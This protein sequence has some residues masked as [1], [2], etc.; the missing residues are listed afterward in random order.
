MK[1]VSQATYLSTEYKFKVHTIQQLVC[2][3]LQVN[4][5]IPTQN[6]VLVHL[7]H[8]PQLV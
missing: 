5:A 2:Q 8:G 7:H 6:V 1:S 3:N 4:H